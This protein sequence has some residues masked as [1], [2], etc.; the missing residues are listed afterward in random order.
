L[1]EIPG[2]KLSDKEVVSSNGDEIGKIY[3]I[4]LNVKTGELADLVVEP[5]QNVDNSNFR[6]YDDLILIPFKKVRAIKDMV[7]VDT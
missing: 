1:T 7:I 3:N 5:R 2:K 6:T 4:T